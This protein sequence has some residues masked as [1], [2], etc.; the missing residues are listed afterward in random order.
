MWDDE[1][2]DDDLDVNTGKCFTLYRIII[3]HANIL[4]SHC[5]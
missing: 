5:I 3:S 1:N 4:Y 2:D